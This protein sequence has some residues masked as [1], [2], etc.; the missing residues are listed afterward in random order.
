MWRAG[1]FFTR[2]GVQSGIFRCSL[3]RQS[4][5]QVFSAFDFMRMASFEHMFHA[6]LFTHHVGARLNGFAIG[7]LHYM[8]KT[9]FGAEMD[10]PPPP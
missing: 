1:I 10:F 2:T 3:W 9:T 4:G 8:T 5:R 6:S 7:F